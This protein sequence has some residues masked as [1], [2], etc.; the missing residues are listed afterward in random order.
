MG[1]AVVVATWFVQLPSAWD[2]LLLP[3]C[4]IKFP[5]MRRRTRWLHIVR[6]M[7][8]AHL[9]SCARRSRDGWHGNEASTP[10]ETPSALMHFQAFRYGCCYLLGWNMLPC[11]RCNA[12]E[13]FYNLKSATFNRQYLNLSHG[14]L[15]VISMTGG[16]CNSDPRFSA[17]SFGSLAVHAN[18]RSHNAMQYFNFGPRCY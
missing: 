7:A 8:R 10:L 3:L 6:A 18:L 16:P 9:T 17:Y 1:C 2:W 4:P 14:I 12:H 11:K 13:L 5:A 15:L